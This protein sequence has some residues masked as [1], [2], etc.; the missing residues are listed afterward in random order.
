MFNSISSFANVVLGAV[1]M[2]ALGFAALL[3]VVH[4]A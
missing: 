4:P 1:P 2:I 3:D